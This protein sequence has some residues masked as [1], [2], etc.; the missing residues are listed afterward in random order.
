M[1]WTCHS[2]SVT[3]STASSEA[4]T[5]SLHYISMIFMKNSEVQ[6]MR[7][8]S[9]SSCLCERWMRTS[10]YVAAANRPATAADWAYPCCLLQLH[11][12]VVTLA[13]TLSRWKNNTKDKRKNLSFGENCPINLYLIGTNSRT[14]LWNLNWD[15]PDDITGLDRKC[16][17]CKDY[18]R[19][20]QYSRWLHCHIGI[21]K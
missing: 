4:E 15:N 11:T 14:I 1:G 2:L 10:S 16:T 7:K 18:F 8:K 20:V 21:G 5:N 13:Q 3:P 6:L 9:I 19:T 17:C 12:D